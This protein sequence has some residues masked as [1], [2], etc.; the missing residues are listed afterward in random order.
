MGLL[1][2]MAE[3]LRSPVEVGSFSHYLQG[4]ST[5]PGGAGFQPSTVGGGF[6]QFFIYITIWENDPI[7]SVIFFKRVG[8]TTT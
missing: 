4:F 5:I 1:L 3:I 2:L 6:K 8:S 7:F